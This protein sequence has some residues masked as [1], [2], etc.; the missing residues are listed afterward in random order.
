MWG[1]GPGWRGPGW[2]P[3]PYR[4]PWGPWGRGPGLLGE[5]IGST[6]GTVVGNAI[7]GPE[8]SYNGPPIV[9]GSANAYDD[10]IKYVTSAPEGAEVHLPLDDFNILVQKNVVVY[11]ADKL[12]YVLGRKIT[13]VTK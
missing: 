10:I 9:V 4:R 5:V 12:P 8:P 7:N 3:G 1:R 2:G 6:I 13:V 11:G